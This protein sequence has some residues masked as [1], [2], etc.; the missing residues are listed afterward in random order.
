MRP[1]WSEEE[2]ALKTLDLLEIF[3]TSGRRKL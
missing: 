3:L 2:A 1:V